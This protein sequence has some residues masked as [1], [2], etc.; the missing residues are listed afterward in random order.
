VLLLSAALLAPVEL[1]I[2]DVAPREESITDVPEL[3]SVEVPAADLAEE[4]AGPD[5]TAP[6]DEEDDVLSAVWVPVGPHALNA[7]RSTIPRP[8]LI[9]MI[10]RL[11]RAQCRP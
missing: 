10:M 2:W 6:D 3:P 8:W 5:V 9:R 4:G 7:T 1:A 11:P